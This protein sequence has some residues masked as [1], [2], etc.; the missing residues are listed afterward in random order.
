M[1][2]FALGHGLLG[3]PREFAF[4]A[5]TGS[6]HFCPQATSPGL[7]ALLFCSYTLGQ[8][9]TSDCVEEDPLSVLAYS[10]V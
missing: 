4:E 10:F 9:E 8:L 7:N 6:A 2:L 5:R 1:H 3:K